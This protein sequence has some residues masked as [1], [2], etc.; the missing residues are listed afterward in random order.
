MDTISIIIPCYNMEEKIGKCISSIKNQSYKNFEAIFVD[1]GSTD[2]TKEII[3]ENIKNDE[4]M[5]Y[6]Y[7]EN[8]GVASSRN[9]EKGDRDLYLLYRQR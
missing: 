5:K 8:G 6:F 1:D 3:E 9:Y 2:K 4:R 7:K